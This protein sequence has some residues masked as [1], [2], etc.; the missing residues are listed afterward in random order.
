VY[1]RLASLEPLCEICHGVHFLYAFDASGTLR[2]F[3]PVHVTKWGNEPWSDE[4]VRFFES[5]LVG[6]TLDGLAFDEEVDAVS[7]ATISSTI[8]FLEIGEAGELL[9]AARGL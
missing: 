1:V 8:M 6:R 9:E 2:G 7:R 3:E 5:R 4:D